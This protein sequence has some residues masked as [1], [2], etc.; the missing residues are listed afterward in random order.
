MNI[1]FK[2]RKM[3]LNYWLKKTNQYHFLKKKLKIKRD[4]YMSS[5]SLKYNYNSKQKVIKTTIIFKT[6]ANLEAL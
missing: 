2:I 5:K 6:N 3:R 4:S 1:R